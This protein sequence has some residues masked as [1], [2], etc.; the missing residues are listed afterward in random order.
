MKRSFSRYRLALFAISLLSSTMFADV[1]WRG[2]ST[3]DVVDENLIIK[4]D[5]LLALGGTSIKAIHKD[6]TVTLTRD[7][8][9]SGHWAGESDLYLV[10]AEGRKIRFVLDHNLTFL[11]SS[12]ITGDDLLIVQSGPGTVEV[13]LGDGKTFELTS[14]DCSGGALYYVLMYGGANA[15]VDEYCCEEYCSTGDCCDEY[16][17]GGLFHSNDE[18]CG[19]EYCTPGNGCNEN[20]LSRPTL[21]FVSFE[22]N[23]VRAG[24]CCNKRVVVGP[25]SRMSFL[26]S[27]KTGVGQ[28]AG[29]IQFDAAIN[30]VRRMILEVQNTGAF[31]ATGHYTCQRRG[32]CI[33]TQDINLAVA[34]G[35]NATWRIFNNLGSTVPAG[36][37][38]LDK[39]DTLSDLLVDPFLNLGARADLTGYRGTFSGKRYG[40]VLGANGTLAVD[41]NSYLDF[42][43]LALNQV[44]GLILADGCSISKLLKMR[45]ASA[46]IVDGNL[47]PSA[48]DAQIIFG[49]HA[50]FFLRSGIGEDGT[51]RDE[52]DVDPFTVDASNR[53]HGVGNIVLDVEGEVDVTGVLQSDECECV[54]SK[55]ELLSLEVFPTGGPLF[56][57]SH[58]TNFPL[59]TFNTEDNEL[60]MYNCGAFLVNNRM[61]LYTTALNHTDECHSICPNNDLRSEPAYVGGETWKLLGSDV[62]PNIRFINA[63]FEIHT[64]VALTGLD[65]V[66]P[67][68]VDELGVL[69]NNVSAF[70]FFSN[71]SCVDNGTGRQMILGTRIGSTAADGCSRIDAD[72]HLDI[73]EQDEAI[74]SEIDPLNLD[75]DQT[76]LLLTSHNDDSINNNIVDNVTTSI[77]TIFLGGASNISVGVNADTTGFNIDTHPWLS[78]AGNVF[79]FETRSGAV[80]RSIVTGKNAIFVD[81]NGK[82]S[83]EP[84]FIANICTMVIKSHN[85]IVDLPAEQV[86]FCDGA[87]IATWDINLSNP[88]DQIIIGPDQALSTFIL[89]WILAKKDCSNYIPF[90]CC[91]A[92]CTCPTVTEAN[93]TSL[94]TIQGEVNDLQIQGTR[95]GDP[96]QI[97]ID[98]GYVRSL[99]FLPTGCSAEAPVAVVV[100][101]NNGRV[102]LDNNAMLGLNG[103]TIIANGSGQ[104]IVNSDLTIN[105]VCAIVKGPDFAGCGTPQLSAG[106]VLEFYSAVP[107]EIRVKSTGTLNLA[108]FTDATDIVAIAGEL[109]LV[110]EPGATIITGAGV[111]RFAGNSEMLFEPSNIAQDFFTAIPHGAHDATLGITTIDAAEMHNPLSALTNFGSGLH[112]TDQFRVKLVGT[113]TIE[114]VDNATASVPFNAFVGVE[115]LSNATCE[116]TTTDLKLNIA[117]NGVFAIGHFNYNEGGALQI[118]NVDDRGENHTVNFTLILDGENAN[119][120]IGSRGF[121]GLGVGIERFDGQPELLVRG[122]TCPTNF[123]PNENIVNTLNNVDEITFR[124]LNGR[125]EH[126]RIFSGDDV[127]ASLVA[128]G[129]N[130]GIQFNLDFQLPDEN[131]NP[132]LQ[133]V[134]DFNVAGG[135]NMVLVEQGTG[136]IHPIVLDQDGFI[137]DRLNAG[138]MASTLLQVA[139]V[140]TNGLS[141]AQF[142]DYMKTHDALLE[143]ARQNTFG[144]ANVASQGDSFRPEFD[145]ARLDTVSNGIIIRGALYDLF[146]PGTE[147]SKRRNAVDMA[148]AFIN[149]DPSLNE[150]LTATNI[151]D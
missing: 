64:D 112:N 31:V 69:R 34:A 39:N 4:D 103:I 102:G 142:F 28:D 54:T 7:A 136:G 97:L 121:L 119:F 36:L 120:T 133:R 77:H 15:P 126:D 94:P 99:T 113:G 108:S 140:D 53:T 146:G 80:S 145:G 118:G 8:V 88:E 37:L 84:G 45:N 5:V 22:S 56:V 86:F 124:F 20:S 107:H 61:N 27:R 43:G 76:L 48:T 46:F 81:L 151:E 144:R 109:K 72:A 143:F 73:M 18:Y 63:D 85:G 87:G 60:L 74:I 96:A 104:V 89:N 79:S 127:N 138:I 105:N 17:S 148:A 47:N 19:E 150:I 106:D 66:V 38:V 3:C 110:L 13:A 115:T 75:G 68:F 134:S 29:T 100:L 92:S 55:I 123:I 135:G 82:F 35:F 10:A 25:K 98:G 122:R 12:Q 11:G 125:F 62:R 6:V 129:N 59:R 111:L 70:T 137:T 2:T 58:E 91:T 83:I 128:I 141:G 101:E 26:S 139:N 52:F 21:S 40:V 9:L 33:T 116:I 51:I 95:I 90:D 32:E 16:V 49:E 71:G 131:V 65:L 23:N 130:T 67:N 147:E 41:A 117:D 42:V 30:S 24:N 50:A 1:I 114:L 132:T 44:P 78:I 57:G 149:I 14:Q 93:V